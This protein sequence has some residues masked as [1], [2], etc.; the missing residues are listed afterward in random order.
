MTTRW[1]VRVVTL[2]LALA[3]LSVAAGRGQSPDAP[4]IV[5]QTTSAGAVDRGLAPDAARPPRGAWRAVRSAAEPAVDTDRIG[6]SGAPYVPGRVIVRFRDATSAATRRAAVSSVSPTAAMS[7]RLPNAN[8]DLVAL[9]P[10]EDAEAAARRF[11]ARGDV[12]YAQAAYR[13][14]P[15]MIPNDPLYRLQWNMP[16]IDMERAWDIQ[17]GATESVIVAVIDTGVAFDDT[18]LRMNARPFRIVFPNGSSLLYPALG[19]I[20]VP[21]AAAPDLRGPNRFVTPRDFI[22]DDAFPFDTDGHGTHVSGT[23]GQL[24]NNGI[25]TVGVAYNV[26]LMPI[27]VLDSVWDF[28]FSS[29]YE[30]TDDTVAR[31]IR[32]AADNGARVLN[33]SLG[34]TGPSAPVVEDA[35]RYAISKGAFVVV[36]GGNAFETGNP[37][38]ILPEIASRV[39][40]AVSVAALDQQHN[41]AYYSSTG[42][43]IELSA[44]GGS[45]RVS[46]AAGTIYQQT[47]DLG[48]VNTYDLPP[49]LYRA[50]R[51][52]IFVYAPFQGTSMAAPHVSGLA[53]LLIQQG[54][55]SP[56][57]IE[58]AMRRFAT[59]RGPTGRDDEF[60]YG[61][62]N[63]RNTLRGLGLSN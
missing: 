28:I 42:S 45:S 47:Y 53:A 26:R 62:I 31:G 19:I 40:G 30:G 27:K 59:D 29:P 16:A 33:L 5:L 22:W 11:A 37:L 8:F 54:I 23:V 14:H 57:A 39:D 34:R 18:I 51:F 2:A 58:S 41:R 15:Y 13:M 20:D 10:S 44:P 32:Y 24:T 12:E 50:P 63:A 36:S 56:A 49:S 3:A 60:G 17:P 9:D 25:G 7:A 4:R 21:F 35:I 61:E 1:H 46:G 6:S 43:F 52:D 48:F 55:T 38:E